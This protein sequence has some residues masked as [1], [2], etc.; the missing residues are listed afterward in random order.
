[1]ISP[2]E[3]VQFFRDNY[4]KPDF[5]QILP[6]FI[7]FGAM[8]YRSSLRSD[9]HPRQHPEE[10]LKLMKFME[11]KYIEKYMEIGI[12]FGGTFMVMDAFFRSVNPNFKE[13]IGID[14]RL[15]LNN[16]DEQAVINTP[17]RGKR[18][19]NLDISST[20]AFQEYRNKYPTCKFVHCHSDDYKTN[21]QFDLIFIDSNGKYKSL[22]KTF[23]QFK[24]CARYIA[25]HDICDNRYG[26]GELFKDL[27]RKYKTVNL[28]IDTLSPGI[29]L[30]I[31][32]E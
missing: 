9:I 30:V 20:K 11:D 2:S 29:G 13:S 4:S 14:K 24:D 15:D 7:R 31:F 23:E 10:L 18:Y 25:L 16:P 12:E 21:D 32:K 22:K 26:T 6:T 19:L 1:M 17:R 28:S 3:L 27:S 5:A 8:G